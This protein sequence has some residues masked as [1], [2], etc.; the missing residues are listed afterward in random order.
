MSAWGTLARQVRLR[1]WL[2]VRSREAGPLFL[3]VTPLGMTV[4]R[5]LAAALLELGIH[6]VRRRPLSSYADLSSALYARS[7]SRTAARRSLTYV[8]AWREL[9]DDYGEDAELWWLTPPEAHG[10]LEAAKRELRLRLA[11]GPELRVRWRR[12]T[13][14]AFHLPDFDRLGIELKLVESA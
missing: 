1:G 3:I 11:P 6:V 13:L 8:Q 10:R 7:A 12:L 9:A 4:R 5:E 2:R 14:H